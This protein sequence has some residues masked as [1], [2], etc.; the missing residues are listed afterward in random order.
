MLRRM[1]T[2]VL[3]LAAGRGERL[4]GSTPKAFVRLAGRTLIERSVAT[5]LSLDEVTWVQPVVPAGFGTTSRE[6]GLPDDPRVLPA[7]PGGAERQDSVACG[8]DALPGGVAC[9]AIHDAARCLVDAADV[10]RVLAAARTDRAALLAVPAH[11]TIKRV[12]SGWVTD[13]PPRGECW[14]AQTPQVFPIELLREAIAK[15]RADGV[16][17]TDDAQLVE[18]LGVAVRVVEGSR[19]NLKITRPEDLMLAETLLSMEEAEG[20]PA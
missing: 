15:A 8:L 7:V 17:G 2:A 11:D 1:Q 14:V 19:R 9:V 10:A 13:T 20:G 18:R 4:G 12:R 6:L 5:M 16:V 3:V